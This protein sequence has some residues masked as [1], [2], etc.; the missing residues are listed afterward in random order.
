MH[1]GGVSRRS[2]IAGRYGEQ[3]DMLRECRP[4]EHIFLH[5][6]SPGC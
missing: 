1:D 6:L 5:P 3:K 2:A 4:I